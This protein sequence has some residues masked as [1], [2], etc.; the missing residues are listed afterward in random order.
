MNIIR[1]FVPDRTLTGLLRSISA[2]AS[3]AS[4]ATA[5]L[6]TSVL[7]C[8]YLAWKKRSPLAAE[9]VLRPLP[10]IADPYQI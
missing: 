7:Q 3:T 8:A 9:I 4:A 10:P 6:Y 2:L 5:T 1:S